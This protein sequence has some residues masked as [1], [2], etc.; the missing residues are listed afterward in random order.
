MPDNF[1]RPLKVFLCHAHPDADKV[2]ALY[3]RLKAD[4]V[5][6]WLDKENIIPGQDW[7]MEIRKAVRESDIVVV[8]LS[9][10]FSQKGYRQN[11][12]RIALE[13]ASLQPEGEIFIIPA[14]LEECNYLESLKRFHGVDLFEERGYEYLMRALRLRADKIG[15][16]LQAKRSWL[17]NITIPRAT[18]RKSAE[19][20]KPESPKKKLA[21]TPREI[22]N[23]KIQQ[24]S[25][26]PLP[27]NKFPEGWET[28]WLPSH[29]SEKSST[30]QES[31]ENLEP[32][33]VIAQKP[34]RKWNT[35]MIAAIAGVIVVFAAIF[36][37]PWN[38]WFSAAPD[39]VTVTPTRTV[40][41]TPPPLT[42]T[43]T[44]ASPTK[45]STPVFTST[46][47][48][49]QVIATPTP[50]TLKWGDVTVSLPQK[51]ITLENANQVELITTLP[52][53]YNA[54]YFV[55]SPTD[56]YVAFAVGVKVYTVGLLDGETRYAF[57]G[58]KNN[59]GC[60]AIS[61]DGR[62][63][64]TGSL[65]EIRVWNA[66]TGALIKVLEEV[67]SLDSCNQI[68]FSPD[69]TLLLAFL[70]RYSPRVEH[71][72][73]WKASDWAYWTLLNTL[74]YPESEL[75]GMDISPDSTL[76]AIGTS[77]NSVLL[78]NI[79]EDNIVKSFKEGDSDFKIVK[80][81]ADGELLASVN[82]EGTLWVWDV[83]SGSLVSSLKNFGCWNMFVFNDQALMCQLGNEI[84]FWDTTAMKMA[85]KFDYGGYDVGI[86]HNR[87]L[88]VGFLPYASYWNYNGHVT[89]KSKVSL[90]GIP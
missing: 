41:F 11:E 77:D 69:G 73:A 12:V 5:D 35:R 82:N 10:Q 65:G 49:A 52:S 63:L 38:Q 45:T 16:V 30:K 27:A 7:E 55:L 40:I 78:W 47:T 13:E 64:V 84:Y 56:E 57:E 6:A 51:P 21:E 90:W 88:L 80:F 68:V 74:S 14:R 37:L 61:P 67:S 33:P 20:K 50:K 53:P 25:E 4:G 86:T 83:K 66:E 1:N 36:G 79:A 59:V 81:S 58:H 89:T 75:F 85:S 29:E 34:P 43:F 42:M 28:E 23:S 44:L 26:T 87:N 22:P 8:C 39:I 24:K 2:R 9:K 18:S 48:P 76:L 46:S 17:P 54:N 19:I 62:L 60:V 15:A 71:I 31:T 70:S 32:K 72:Q 3:A